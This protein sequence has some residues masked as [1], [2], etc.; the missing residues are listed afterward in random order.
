M[1]REKWSGGK[2]R[3][4]IGVVRKCRLRVI[5]VVVA[6]VVDVAVRGT[7]AGRVFGF[8]SHLAYQ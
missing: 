8:Q 3:K 1:W 7:M 4:I 2:F 6:V 5:L